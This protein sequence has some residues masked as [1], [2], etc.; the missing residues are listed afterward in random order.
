MTLAGKTA[1]V[2]G[3]SGTIGSAIAK[4]LNGLGAHVVAIDI[5]E[6]ASATRNVG[7]TRCRAD[8]SDKDAIAAASAELMDRLV[9][10]TFW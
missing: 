1:A 8:L 7:I 4:A 6:A 9:R 5:A 3:A 10:S 2:T